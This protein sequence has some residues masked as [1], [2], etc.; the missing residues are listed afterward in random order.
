MQSHAGAPRP[1]GRS[2]PHEATPPNRFGKKQGRH[3]DPKPGQPSPPSLLLWPWLGLVSIAEH[4]RSCPTPS[5]SIQLR[6]AASPPT[7]HHAP[8]PELPP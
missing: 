2:W 3:P 6:S 1:R 4:S 5:V 7:Q 8:S